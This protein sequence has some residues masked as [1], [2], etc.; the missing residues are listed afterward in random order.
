ML[1]NPQHIHTDFA[2]AMSNC[3]ILAIMHEELIDVFGNFEEEYD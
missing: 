1:L 3:Q 2:R